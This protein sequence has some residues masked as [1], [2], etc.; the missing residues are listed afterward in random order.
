M[1]FFIS[2]RNKS[3]RAAG[4]PPGEIARERRLLLPASAVDLQLGEKGEINI[5]SHKKKKKRKIN[6]EPKNQNL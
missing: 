1:F 2:R 6:H 5:K 4:K 3:Y